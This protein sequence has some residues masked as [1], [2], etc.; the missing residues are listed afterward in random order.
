MARLVRQPCNRCKY[1]S[2]LKC[3][4]EIGDGDDDGDGVERETEEK[5]GKIFSFSLISHGN[6]GGRIPVLGIATQQFLRI[7]YFMVHV[8]CFCEN[9]TNVSDSKIRILKLL[10]F[11]LLLGFYFSCTCYV[12]CNSMTFT[13]KT[14]S[15]KPRC[16]LQCKYEGNKNLVTY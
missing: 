14:S 5:M 11:R 2:R 10:A 7:F 6:G 4:H 15:N 12:A 13:P 1:R 16:L 3:T 9:I 8:L